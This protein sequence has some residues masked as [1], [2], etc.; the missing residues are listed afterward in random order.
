M[1]NVTYNGYR[2]K[3]QMVVTQSNKSVEGGGRCMCGWV[4]RWVGWVGEGVGGAELEP[5]LERLWCLTYWP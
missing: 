4:G 3:K 5:E 1:A 2:Q